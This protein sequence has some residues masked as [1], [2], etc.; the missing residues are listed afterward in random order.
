V[1]GPVTPPLA[2]ALLALLVALFALLALVAV[3]ARVR[4]LEAGRAA[5]A[6]PSGYPALTGRPGP[7]AVRPRSGERGALVAVVDADC[8]LCREVWHALRAADLPGVRRVAVADRAGPFTG[9][10]ADLLVDPDLRAALFEG[11][12][13]TLLA[14]DAAGTVTAR[15]FVY[16]DTDLPGLVR[17]LGSDHP[18]RPAREVRTA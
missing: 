7:A 8:V 1:G 12:S 13:P 18:H 9:V 11:Y 17:H 14:L 2:V 10:G 16:A 4:A 3:H 5:F 15:R 6:D